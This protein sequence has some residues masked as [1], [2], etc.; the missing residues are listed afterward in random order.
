MVCRLCQLLVPSSAS[1]L[2][3]V[4]ILY[5]FTRWSYHILFTLTP[6][7]LGL[8]STKGDMC[9]S[10]NC[11]SQ[12]QPSLSLWHSGNRRHNFPS[13]VHGAGVEFPQCVLMKLMTS[14][15]YPSYQGAQNLKL[16][17]ILM[18][19]YIYFEPN[20]SFLRT[21]CRRQFRSYS[22]MPK[23]WNFQAMLVSSGHVS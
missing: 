6:T 2:C 15:C 5:N 11:W 18:G 22:W 7:I 10:E 3:A 8:T 4:H 17:D 16:G 1:C 12:T 13:S 9:M 14:L 19:M 21:G 20:I 23:F